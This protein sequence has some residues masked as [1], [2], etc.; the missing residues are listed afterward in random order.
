MSD[1]IS[2]LRFTIEGDKAV[3]EALDGE[4]WSAVKGSGD[5]HI[6]TSQGQS[7]GGDVEY[8][9]LDPNE[10]DHIQRHDP[11]GTIAR[12]EAELALLDEMIPTIE[13][14]DYIAMSE[15]LGSM[16]FGEPVA[17]LLRL[18]VSGYR[19]RP[20]FHPSWLTLEAPVNVPFDWARTEAEIADGRVIDP[21]WRDISI[22]SATTRQ[23]LG[24]DTTM[25]EARNIPHPFVKAEGDPYGQVED[26]D[27]SWFCAACGAILS[28]M[29]HKESWPS[30]H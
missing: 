13:E 22:A 8:G 21:V 26:V 18:M 4:T 20:G 28:L 11:R 12:C 17:L 30:R 29:A 15:G 1:L 16:A 5:W 25:A 2:W 27:L 3:A 14:L 19:H 24:L 10:A 9:E 7:F 23:S 6:Q